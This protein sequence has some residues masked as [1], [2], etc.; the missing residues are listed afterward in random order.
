M[1]DGDTGYVHT[2]ALMG[3]VITIQVVGRGANRRER[4]EREAAVARAIRWFHTINESCTRFDPASEV[5]R[6]ST[7]VGT[8]VPVSALV[9]EAVQFALAVAEASQ[10]AFDPTVGLQLEARGFNLDYRS[11]KQVHTALERDDAVTFRDVEL[12]PVARTITL[13]RPLL[14]DL[15]AVAK[16]LAIDMAAR[17]LQPFENFAIDAGGDLYLGGRNADGNPWSV[18][19]RH[20]RDE[21]EVIDTLQ[22]SDL[23]V[24]TSGDYERR[25]P[26]GSTDHHI[27]DP[28]TGESASALA[29]VT[30]VARS[31]L[32]ADA[33]GTAAFVLGPAEGLRLLERHGV[34]GMMITPAM[35]R[36]M[37]PGMPGHHHLANA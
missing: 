10:G 35:E 30:V 23:S 2:V 18:G 8:A 5:S 32:L 14:L 20:P 29:S 28:R 6:L 9:F 33:L 26:G 24:C 17:E 1:S 22:L 13:R 19:I 25:S 21:H 16:G 12:D 27:I 7:Q 15:G 34:D 3:T 31:A 37:T 36:F 4:L 11:G